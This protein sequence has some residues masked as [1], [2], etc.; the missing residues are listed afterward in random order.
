MGLIVSLRVDLIF[1]VLERG[2][3]S[4]QY[5]FNNYACRVVYSKKF[6][7]DL[8]LDGAVPC[9]YILSLNTENAII[10]QKRLV[11]LKGRKEEFGSEASWTPSIASNLFHKL[12][13]IQM[14]AVKSV[15]AWGH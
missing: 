12:Y 13:G 14:L 3:T 15:L 9:S 7:R 8:C 2:G 6:F 11:F 4:S 10:Y 5:Y 1:D